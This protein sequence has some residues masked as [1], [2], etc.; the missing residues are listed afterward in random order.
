MGKRDDG[1]GGLTD[2]QRAFVDQVEKGAENDQNDPSVLAISSNRLIGFSDGLARSKAVQTALKA[3]S[4]AKAVVHTH[5]AVDYL[6]RVAMGVEKADKHRIDACNAL[7]RLAGLPEPAAAE[8]SEKP[9]HAKSRQELE[10]EVDAIKREIANRAAPMIEIEAD[11]I[12]SAQGLRA[13][14]SQAI[15]IYG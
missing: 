14:D 1:E 3:G 6:G 7:F 4:V 11:P 9:L 10:L 2:R 15:D 13:T 5:A 8:R 12:D